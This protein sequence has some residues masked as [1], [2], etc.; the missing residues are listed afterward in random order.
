MKKEWA[1][2]INEKA[3]RQG[4]LLRKIREASGLTMRQ[5]AMQV[6]ISH[7][8]I[9]QVEHGKLELPRAWIEQIVAACGHAVEDFD[10]LMGA[11]QV[12]IDH[13]IECISLVNTLEEDDLKLMFNLMSRIR[14]S[15]KLELL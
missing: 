13:R 11:G 15:P 7:P 10:K 1:N 6:G 4:N 9:S 14:K 12:A 2:A 5:L 8:A 3:K